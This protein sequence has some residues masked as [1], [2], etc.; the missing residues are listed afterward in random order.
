MMFP[1]QLTLKTTRSGTR[2]FSQPVREIDQLHKKSHKWANLTAA[3]AN[4]NVKVVAGDIFRLKM[5][6]QITDGT[7]FDVKYRGNSIAH[8]D[9]NHNKLN[10]SFYPGDDISK[11]TFDLEILVDRTSVEVFADGGKFTSIRAAEIA[12]NDEGFKFGGDIKIHMLEIHE[13]NSIWKK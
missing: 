10:G 13:L 9:M 1:T 4:E 7:V 11:L 8:Y 6:I 12:K 5:K 2:L 3:E